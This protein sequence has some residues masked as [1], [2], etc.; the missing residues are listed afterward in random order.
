MFTFKKLHKNQQGQAALEAAIIL[1]A[2]VV[3][4]SLFAFAVLSAGT[5]STEKGEQAI[6][7][8]L[9]G[10]QA[11]MQLRGAVV[12]Q[13]AAAADTTVD[14]VVFTVAL[15]N[16]GQPVDLN[17]TDKRTLIGYRDGTNFANDLDYTVNWLGNTDGDELL[18]EGELAELTVT[19]EAGSPAAAVLAANTRFTL[20]VK[21]QQGGVLAIDRTTPANLDMVMELR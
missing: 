3:V 17:T 12:A 13:K 2:F 16:G 19:V 1:I 14:T 6:Y 8:G 18:E 20:E 21:P 5:S 11:S 7:A 9:E 15:V 10:V 4:A